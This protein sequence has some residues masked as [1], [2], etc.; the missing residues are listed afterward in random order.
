MK[1]HT[2]LT[3][4]LI[5]ITAATFLFSGCNKPKER[6]SAIN[7]KA[8][9]NIFAMKDIGEITSDSKTVYY[10]GGE[11]DLADKTLK[12]AKIEGKVQDLLNKV[13]GKE[14]KAMLD[15]HLKTGDIAIV[16]LDDQIKILKVVPETSS[17]W[18]MTLTSLAYLSK[19]KSLVKTSDAKQQASL[20]SEMESIKDKSPFQMGEAMGLAEITSIKIEKHGNLDNER[21]DYNEKKSLLNVIDRPFDVSTHL[22]VGGEVG[23]DSAD[24]AEKTAEKAAQ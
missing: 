15:E 21:T 11:K 8:A 3:S 9:A 7:P 17:T 10:S 19:L 6:A 24:A 1:K 14:T 13:T 23:A 20:V 2:T 4:T 16:M 18:E 12:Q 5:V 22:L